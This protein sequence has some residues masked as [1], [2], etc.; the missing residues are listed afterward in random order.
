MPFATRKAL[1]E[2]INNAD[3]AIQCAVKDSNIFD[4]FEQF[5]CKLVHIYHHYQYLG[6]K[7][8]KTKIFKSREDKALRAELDVPRFL[9]ECC[10]AY[11]LVAKDESINNLKFVEAQRKVLAVF[12]KNQ[13]ESN[14]AASAMPP[15]Q[16]VA[17]P[18][19]APV[20]TTII[21][22]YMVVA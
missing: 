5:K 11:K 12:L 8:K 15:C 6:W 1:R 2:A 20:V 13:K 17:G 21:Y 3:H 22:Q 18:S 16:E 14:G 19:K 7:K 9:F 10:T 4:V